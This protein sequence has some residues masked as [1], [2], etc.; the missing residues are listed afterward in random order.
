MLWKSVMLQIRR[1]DWRILICIAEVYFFL[2][3]ADLSLL[4]AM[5]IQ[6]ARY[7]IRRCFRV[8]RN[9]F[10][11]YFFPMV[12]HKTIRS[13]SFADIFQRLLLRSEYPLIRTNTTNFKVA[14]GPRVKCP[15]KKQFLGHV[16]TCHIDLTTRYSSS[17]RLSD[18][19]VRRSKLANPLSSF[20][21]GRQNETK[22]AHYRL[23]ALQLPTTGFIA[24]LKINE[25]VDQ[26]RRT[27]T[28]VYDDL[29]K[30]MT[31]EDYRVD[32]PY[33]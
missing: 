2:T 21:S 6:T 26:R 8:K 27:P 25:T 29:S 19:S 10:V 13:S 16:R 22:M 5:K 9:H 14:E 23:V 30:L 7:F 28:S 17:I 15:K 33:V 12:H 32:R 31:A 1:P 20:Q 3:R 11:L 24:P 4:V 18:R